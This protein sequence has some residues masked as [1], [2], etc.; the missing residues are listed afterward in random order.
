MG[1][2]TFRNNRHSKGPTERQPPE[3]SDRAYDFP[4]LG[5]PAEWASVDDLLKVPFTIGALK[6]PLTGGWWF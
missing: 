1:A 4:A 3:T 6:Q 2:V 5:L